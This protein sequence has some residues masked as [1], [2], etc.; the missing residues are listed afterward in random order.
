VVLNEVVYLA[1]FSFFP[2]AKLII[3]GIMSIKELLPHFK[4]KKENLPG[5]REILIFALFMIFYKYSRYIA[6]GDEETAF[7]NAYLIIE[8]EKMMGIYY[9]IQWQQFVIDYTVLI[10]WVNEFYMRIHLPSTI[11]FFIWLFHYKR[12]YYFFIRNGFLIANIITLFIFIGF[13]CAPPRMLN[14]LGFVDT[15]LTISEIDLY[16]GK[17]SE[18]FN[19]YAAVP[20][21]HFGNALLISLV[22]LVLS[23]NTWV[24]FGSFIYP[25][26][27]LWM[28]V[29][30]GN[31][32][33]LDAVF[34]G[35]VVL[36]PYPFMWM[37]K[38]LFPGWA[39]LSGGPAAHRKASVLMKQ[40]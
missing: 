32:F 23:K 1:F 28:I 12:P 15:L 8:W 10:K 20:S 19:Q 16:E 5:Y 40:R 9:E 25:V 29:I 4:F 11:I 6:I 3:K 34:G 39:W 31:H 27:V 21:M 18:L 26:F 36:A 22:C 24:K 7:Q 17:L 37:A 13:P 30:T 33:F 38:K 2:I 14:E 35:I